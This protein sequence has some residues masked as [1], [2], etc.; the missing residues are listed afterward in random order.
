MD[1]FIHDAAILYFF[2]EYLDIIE[3]DLTWY[4]EEYIKKYVRSNF[5]TAKRTIDRFITD[6]LAKK[7]KNQKQN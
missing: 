1:I 3:K 6:E 7:V 5:D 4:N 2:H